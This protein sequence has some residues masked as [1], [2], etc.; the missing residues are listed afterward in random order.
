MVSWQQMLEQKEELKHLLGNYE[1]RQAQIEMSQAVAQGLKKAQITLIEA[2]TGTGKTLAYLLAALDYAKKTNKR[3]VISTHTLPLQEQILRR[4]LPLAS[5]ML[6]I[7]IKAHLLKGMSNYLCL[8][9]SHQYIA[10]SFLKADL[11]DDDPTLSQSLKESK[12]LSSESS[13]E[14][15]QLHHW[16]NTAQT[17][18]RSEGPRLSN[19][20]WDQIRAADDCSRSKCPYYQSCFYFNS[21]QKAQEATVVIINHHLLVAE[22][23]RRELDGT[24]LIGEWDCLI[25]DEAHHLIDVATQQLAIRLSEQISAQTLSRFWVASRNEGAR[26]WLATL[27]NK[28]IEVF[29]R[30]DL[31]VYE[32]VMQAI[33]KVEEIWQSSSHLSASVRQWLYQSSTNQL[34]L[35][36]NWQEDSSPALQE[37]K[38]QLYFHEQLLAQF[39]VQL[40]GLVLEINALVD[41]LRFVTFTIFIQEAQVLLKMLERYHQHVGQMLKPYDPLSQVMWIE[42]TIQ[43]KWQLQLANFD[44]GVALRKALLEHA[45]SAVLCSA[46]LGG[47]QK[48]EP[49]YSELRLNEIAEK[50]ELIKFESSFDWQKQSHLLVCSDLPS[51]NENLY[52]KALESAVSEIVRS[53]PGRILILTTSLD[54]VKDLYQYLELKQNKRKILYQTQSSR[55]QLL[56][57]F[58]ENESAILI[59]ADS[60]WEGIDLAGQAL[61]CVILARLPFDVPSDPLIQAKAQALYGKEAFWKYLLPRAVLRFQQGM[62]RLLRHSQ[63]KGCVICLDSRLVKAR[64]GAQFIKSCGVEGW[65]NI[66]SHQLADSI[67]LF[68]NPV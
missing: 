23:K 30:P 15:S 38:N 65:Q 40:D 64:Y 67:H 32:L 39:V 33:Q 35:K 22:W 47:T 3:I 57:L 51:P 68:F 60:F 49:I 28:L 21:R 25:I 8:R 13:L 63:D 20:H 36:P 10:Q 6:G 26:G 31:P 17:G 56:K 41:Q 66:R 52:A 12:E 42:S 24:N 34:S 14:A 46:T 58:S 7:D 27:R 43:G 1:L 50:V 55:E 5:Q 18:L 62:G 48:F 16:M 45:H 4:D 9:N 29:N 37:F 53:C 54:T 59:G 2:P 19:T 44:I 61:S 11:G